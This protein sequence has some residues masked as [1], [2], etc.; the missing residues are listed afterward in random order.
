MLALLLIQVE[1]RFIR[2]RNR[3]PIVNLWQF[4]KNVWNIVFWDQEQATHTSEGA[5]SPT[6]ASNSL[7]IQ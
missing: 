3:I 5:T 4:M 7:L 6:G 2:R 1:P